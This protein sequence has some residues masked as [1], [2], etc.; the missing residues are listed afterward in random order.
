M[1]ITKAKEEI[2]KTA[3]AYFAKDADGLSRISHHEQRPVLLMGPPGVGKTAVV[4]QVAAELGIGFLSYSMT[5]H[6]RQ[7][8]LGL[9]AI[10]EREYKGMRFSVSEYTMSE[11]IASVYEQMEKTGCEEGIL[12]LDEINCVSETLMPVMLQFLQYKVFGR[13]ELPEGWMVVCAGNPPEYNRSAKVFDVVTLDRMKVIEIEPD[14]EAWR[15]Y[16]ISQD[17]HP[18]VLR[19]LNGHPNYFYEITGTGMH[20]AFATARGW[21]DLSQM[22]LVCEE[23]KIAVDRHLA[24]QY[25]GHPQAAEAFAAYYALYES[26]Q[27]KD[28]V[29]EILQGVE[30]DEIH[31][32]AKAADFDER[33]S[34]LSQ[35][36]SQTNRMLRE[37]LLQEDVVRDLHEALLR[38]REREELSDA[39]LEERK[40]I[41]ERRE[42]DRLRGILARRDEKLWSRE[43]SFLKECLAECG[44]FEEVKTSFQSLVAEMK[45]KREVVSAVLARLFAFVEDVWP[46]GYE[47]LM[48][49]TELSS[50]KDSAR[51]IAAHGCEAYERHVG[52]LQFEE[53][54]ENILQ[55]IARL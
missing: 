15:S 34:L 40:K 21:M 23:E 39:L 4:S 17:V 27:A 36:L 49:V 5:H 25:I 46:D 18:A 48:L 26:Y 20:K 9:P 13:H 54:R 33:F 32:R 43:I 3:K 11:I 53:R 10:R 38:V 37:N 50:G 12:F 31:E 6:T 55:E 8:A 42:R 2:R 44:T 24:S 45:L 1:N 22:L 30:T 7:S 47:M 28:Q 19:F 52:E 16:A 29:L 51:W 14:Y 35:L 41:E